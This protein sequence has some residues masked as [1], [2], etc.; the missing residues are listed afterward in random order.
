MT[1]HLQGPVHG[2]WTG[3]FV[4]LDFSSL[5]RYTAPLCHFLN[6]HALY[7]LMSHKKFSSKCRC[8]P[9]GITIRWHLLSISNACKARHNILVQQKMSKFMRHSQPISPYPSTSSF[10]HIFPD[11][12]L[13]SLWISQAVIEP[14]FLFLDHL[15]REVVISENHWEDTLHQSHN[16]DVCLILQ[17]ENFPQSLGEFSDFMSRSWWCFVSYFAHSLLLFSSNSIS[18]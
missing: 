6:R 17:S 13:T 7:H 5:M 11:V 2:K 3:L 16:I 1:P 12:N 8:L 10:I 18:I 14:H 15:D 9:F 4:F